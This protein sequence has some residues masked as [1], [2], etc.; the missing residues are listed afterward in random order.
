MTAESQQP[1]GTTQ[2]ERWTAAVSPAPR[3]AT[4]CWLAQL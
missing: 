4:L 3:R 2:P 1:V